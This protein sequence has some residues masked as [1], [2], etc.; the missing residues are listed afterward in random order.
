MGIFEYFFYRKSRKKRDVFTVRMQSDWWRC[1]AK[2]RE[3]W[4]RIRHNQ[5]D[6][7]E[8]VFYSRTATRAP[9]TSLV[10]NI[11]NE[12]GYG[13]LIDSIE[14]PLYPIAKMWL[15]RFNE[16]IFHSVKRLKVSRYFVQFDRW[17]LKTLFLEFGI[18]E[19]F[20]E[21]MQN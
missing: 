13:Q 16:A 8:V 2:W 19:D 12:K 5:C 21:T 18:C 17:N 20:R 3:R 14:A 10:K 1:N 15:S 7:G 6:S 11:T 9:S 4:D